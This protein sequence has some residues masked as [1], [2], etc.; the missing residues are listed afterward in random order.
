[1]AEEIELDPDEDADLDAAWDK[2]S[3]EADDEDKSA[4]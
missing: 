4:K 3:A 1:M 2:L